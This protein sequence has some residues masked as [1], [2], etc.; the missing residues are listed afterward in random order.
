M[1]GCAMIL[2]PSGLQAAESDEAKNMKKKLDEADDLVAEWQ[3]AKAVRLY[4][5]VSRMHA[6]KERM[7]RAKTELQKLQNDVDETLAKADKIIKSKKPDDE[8]EVMAHVEE[9]VSVLTECCEIKY[10]WLGHPN[11]SQADKRAKKLLS[12]YKKLDRA[13]LKQAE[14]EAK[15]QAKEAKGYL[16]AG[17][18]ELRS[19]TEGYLQ[20]LKQY[21]YTKTAKKNVRMFFAVQA[22]S[23][24]EDARQAEEAKKKK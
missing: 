2:C 20:L 4:A 13:G 19:A 17:P 21:G 18:K 15:M 7:E 3:V 11:S 1:V 16:R 8:G 23:K 10:K 6:N 9:V 14:K 22:K 12:K 5:E 24:E